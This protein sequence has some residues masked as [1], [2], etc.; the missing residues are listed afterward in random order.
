MLVGMPEGSCLL[1]RGA[2]AGETGNHPSTAARSRVLWVP[3]PTDE[4]SAH[5]GATS[6]SEHLGGFAGGS[7]Y[8]RLPALAT[9]RPCLGLRGL[10]ECPA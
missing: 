3:R 9:N 10:C 2:R 8:G 6:W 7:V 1:F 5:L 4:T